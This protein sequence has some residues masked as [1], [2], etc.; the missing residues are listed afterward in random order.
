MSDLLTPE[1]LAAIRE[2]AEK[3][4]VGPWHTDD[5]QDDWVVVA[6]SGM[7][8]DIAWEGCVDMAHPERGAVQN[9]AANAT[10]IAAA[11]ADVPALLAHV[12][13]LSEELTEARR[14]FSTATL[15]R[16]IRAVEAERDAALAKLAAVEGERAND[17]RV[18]DGVVAE[19]QQ[20]IRQ[21]DEARAALAAHEAERERWWA[22]AEDLYTH[23][24]E[25]ANDARMCALSRKLARMTVDRHC[26][27]IEAEEDRRALAKGGE[28]G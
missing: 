15:V 19:V 25:T 18:Y 17:L 4:T 14:G 27:D 28:R 23:V 11:R 13:A 5:A 2:R 16:H 1:Q 12:A 7:V 26:G 21:R 8:C 20:A 22:A 6:P 3:A 10:F 9:V 24:H